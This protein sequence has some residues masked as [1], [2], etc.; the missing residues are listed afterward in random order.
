[1]TVITL[2]IFGNSHIFNFPKLSEDA[3]LVPSGD[4]L[5]NRTVSVCPYKIKGSSLN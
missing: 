3:I 4:N 1:M 5:R 2:N